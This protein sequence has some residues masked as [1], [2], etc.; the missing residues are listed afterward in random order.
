MFYK[1]IVDY[2]GI[3]I[4]IIVLLLFV[5]Y[6]YFDKRYKK[7]EQEIPVGY[8]R[9]EEV[10]IDPMTNEKQRVYYHPETGRRIYIKEK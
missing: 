4:I 5:S 9:T 2:Y 7:P 10:S 3:Q 6:L 1:F 8:I